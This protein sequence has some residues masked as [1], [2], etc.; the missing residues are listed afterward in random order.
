ML[1]KEHWQASFRQQWD[2]YKL[3]ENTVKRLETRE[4]N[5]LVVA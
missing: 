1:Y 2:R 4:A 3:Q 5:L